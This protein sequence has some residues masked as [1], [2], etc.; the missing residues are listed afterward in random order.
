[1]TKPSKV[2]RFTGYDLYQWLLSLGIQ[3]Q[4]GAVKTDG[5][6]TESHLK[7]QMP[8]G[9]DFHIILHTVAP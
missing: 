1:M 7:G 4:M 5:E 9:T 6:T 8:D 3:T 2:T